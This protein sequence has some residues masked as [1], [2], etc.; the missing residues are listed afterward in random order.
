MEIK[1]E[2]RIV[3]E[4]RPG[5]DDKDKALN[6]FRLSIFGLMCLLTAIL[7]QL[8]SIA[9]ALEKLTKTVM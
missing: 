3:V 4:A 1:K 8:Y 5:S 6:C 7:L 9:R 2:V